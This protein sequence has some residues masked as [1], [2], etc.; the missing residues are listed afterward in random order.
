[1]KKRDSWKRVGK[2]LPF[3]EYLSAESE[4]SPLFR[5]RYQATV[6]EGTAGWKRLS[7]CCGYL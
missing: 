7:G 1:V 6:R 3:R 4:V 2:E 5:N